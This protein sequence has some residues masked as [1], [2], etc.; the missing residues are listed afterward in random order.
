LHKIPSILSSFGYFAYFCIMT[1]ISAT[2]IAR[3]E[4]QTIRHCIESLEGIA[5]EIIVVVDDTST[6]RTAEISRNH[7]CRVVV[8]KFMGFGAQRQFATSLTTH[9]YVLSIDADEVLSPFLHENLLKQKGQGLNHRVYRFSRMNFYCDSPVLHCGWY[10]DF[11]I[12][13]FDKSYAQWNL[14]DVFEKVVFPGSLRPQLIEGDILHYRCST[15]QEYHN[16]VMGHAHIGA[17]VIA[18]TRS[19]VPSFLPIIKGIKSWF[20]TYVIRGGFLDGRVGIAI[21]GEEFHSTRAAYS[22][23]KEILKHTAP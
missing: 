2:I 17:R 14:G 12:R 18:S 13:L 15:A 19:N 16:K 8:R 7:G 23:A 20:E 11:Q 5:D 9:R 1:P 3:N 10:P 6:D 21:A 22:E 4:E